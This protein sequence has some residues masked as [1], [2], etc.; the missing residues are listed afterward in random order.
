M[1]TK[2]SAVFRDVTLHGTIT[3]TEV[4]HEL[5]VLMTEAASASETSVYTYHTTQ[6]QIADDSLESHTL[7]GRVAAERQVWYMARTLMYL[8][9]AKACTYV[10]GTEK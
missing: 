7:V 3:Y 6:C 9:T 5:A 2:K 4:S 10:T 1:K 8:A